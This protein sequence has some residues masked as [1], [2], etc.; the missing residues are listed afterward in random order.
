MAYLFILTII[1]KNIIINNISV[2]KD[3]NIKYFRFKK[4]KLLN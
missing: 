1:N 3:L 4:E 2:F